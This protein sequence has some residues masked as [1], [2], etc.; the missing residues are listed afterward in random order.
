M[1]CV[2]LSNFSQIL[3]RK[4]Q[5]ATDEFADADE[6]DFVIS[7][8]YETHKTLDQFYYHALW[9]PPEIPL[10]LSDYDTRITSNYMMNDDFLIYD[11]GGM[12]GSSALPS[13]WT[14]RARWK[15]HPA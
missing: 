1:E 4:T 5:L 15:V 8:H 13:S 6:L 2:P 12:A 3:D 14:S 11:D 9:N 7:T 10:N